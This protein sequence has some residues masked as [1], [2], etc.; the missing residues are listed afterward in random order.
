MID[1]SVIIDHLRRYKSLYPFLEYCEINQ[2]EVYISVVSRAEIQSGASM[3][4]VKARMEADELLMTFTPIEVDV[5][6]LV[7]RNIKDFERI[8]NLKTQTV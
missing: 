5:S 1:T 6:I 2:R 8:P 7:T 4:A 3:D